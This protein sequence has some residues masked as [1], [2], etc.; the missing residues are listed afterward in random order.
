MQDGIHDVTDSE[1]DLPKQVR[2]FLW[3][4]VYFTIRRIL[5]ELG[6]GRIQNSVALPGDSPFSQKANTY[7]IPSYNRLY[8]E[9]GI[10]PS[11]D[12]PRFHGGMNHGLGNVFC[13]MC[14]H[15]CEPPHSL[16]NTFGLSY[17]TAGD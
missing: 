7:D 10:H 4:H 1:L 9:F 11:T 8:N 2:P 17:V 6:L 13:F 12:F 14:S 16:Q 15:S 5:F 3:F